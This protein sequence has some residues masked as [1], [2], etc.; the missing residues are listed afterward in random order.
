MTCPDHPHRAPVSRRA[1]L[2]AESS[3][4]ELGDDDGRVDSP[5]R[6]R[7]DRVAHP[8][9][10]EVH[11]DDESVRRATLRAPGFG[12]PAVVHIFR[13]ARHH[14]VVRIDLTQQVH[15]FRVELAESLRPRRL[16][17]PEK[18]LIPQP[19]HRDGGMIAIPL[20]PGDH[21]AAYTPTHIRIAV[22]ER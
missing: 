16:T 12:D 5:S 17:H 9:R 1:I 19:P 8:E 4:R 15:G 14:R 3:R 22:V 10:V 2:A 18:R 7:F 11:A 21:L 6:P 20:H 13:L